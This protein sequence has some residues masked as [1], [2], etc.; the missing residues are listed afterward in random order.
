MTVI[1]AG[2]FFKIT[3][4]EWLIVLL[5]SALVLSLEALNSAIER[6]CDL[7]SEEKNL[8]IKV[9]KDISAGAVLIAAIFA[10]AIG[11]IVFW[12]Y[13]FK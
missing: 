8:K 6:V 2:F 3:E 9:I 4:I 1:V 5:A 12:K 13:I 7:Y 11:V 10:L